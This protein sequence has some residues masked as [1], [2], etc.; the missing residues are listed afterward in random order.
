M[1]TV[2]DDDHLVA[3][4]C[5]RT[6]HRFTGRAVAA[7]FRT[8]TKVARQ[9]TL[10]RR[11]RLLGCSVLDTC[12]KPNNLKLVQR[13]CC[14]CFLS[15]TSSS[16]RW[17]RFR[18]TAAVP[19]SESGGFQPSSEKT[20]F[21]YV[22]FGHVSKV[23]VSFFRLVCFGHVSK[24]YQPKTGSTAVLLLLSF[25]HQ[26]ECSLEQLQVLGRCTDTELPLGDVARQEP[27]GDKHSVARLDLDDR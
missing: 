23:H 1:L 9:D 19:M 5:R 12:P 25:R 27:L 6:T 20:A 11:K 13:P 3:G 15:D 8:E 2:T 17:S 26:L 21:R 14:C 24:T 18:S 10:L 4:W 16:A 22:M 7:F